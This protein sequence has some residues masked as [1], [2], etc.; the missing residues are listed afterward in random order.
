MS[1]TTQAR[2]I[3]VQL[4]GVWY[5]VDTQGEVRQTAHARDYWHPA[6]D[7]SLEDKAIIL[8]TAS[9]PGTRYR[10][11]QEACGARTVVASFSI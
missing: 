1:A 7:M 8:R 10:I 4:R 9:G 6:D 3:E 2:N 11:A 5:W